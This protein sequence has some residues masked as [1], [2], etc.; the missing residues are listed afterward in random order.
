M[1]ISIAKVR[2]LFESAKQ[3]EDFLHSVFTLAIDS[4][5]AAC[6]GDKWGD[7]GKGGQ[8]KGDRNFLPFHN[9]SVRL[10]LLVFVCQI[11]YLLGRESCVSDYLSHG[12]SLVAQPDNDVLLLLTS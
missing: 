4:F 7:R 8:E 10:F 2:I 11:T 12:G 6:W 5:Q 3:F 1:F 9:P